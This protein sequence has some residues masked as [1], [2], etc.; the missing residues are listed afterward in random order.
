MEDEKILT[1]LWRR[2]EHA[3]EAL[4]LRFGR[5]LHQTALNIL[6]SDPDAEEAVNDT[7]LALWNAI[8]PKR[9]QPLAGYV[10]RTGRNIALKK[11]RFLSAQ[12]RSSQYDLSLDEL[13][14]IL[15]GSDLEEQLDAKALGQAINAFLDTLSLQNR[16]IFLRRYWY[17][18]SVDE[19][20]EEF[21]CSPS[22]I[23][24]IL[25]RTRKKLRKHLKKE[26]FRV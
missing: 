20:A 13:A 10:Y 21:R 7:Y 8:P 24:G 6:G 26:G 1:L 12:K 11:L 18:A 19:L 14:D 2:A 17:S 22:K 23:T 3:I 16:R 5:R 9:P 4:Q 15:P 25:F